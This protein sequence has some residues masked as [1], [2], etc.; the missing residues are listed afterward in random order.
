[1]AKLNSFWKYFRNTWLIRYRPEDWNIEAFTNEDTLVTLINRTN[2][3]LERFNR[4]LNQAFPTAHPSMND[5]VATIKRISCE[6]LYKLNRIDC[7]SM[8]K[9]VHAPVNRYPIPV[10]YYSF[11]VVEI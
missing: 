4:E 9:P 10:D 3:P 8:K 2:N 7:G 11:V 5:F 6:Y 1:L